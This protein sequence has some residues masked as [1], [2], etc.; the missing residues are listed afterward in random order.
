MMECPNCKEITFKQIA[1][2]ALLEYECTECTW[3][4]TWNNPDYDP[5]PEEGEPPI[6]WADY[7]KTVRPR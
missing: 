2:G 3:Y 4:G 1:D 5:T 7:A 6:G